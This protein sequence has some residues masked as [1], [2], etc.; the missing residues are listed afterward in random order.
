MA[1]NDP[2]RGPSVTET[3]LVRR[4]ALLAPSDAAAVPALVMTAGEQAGYRFLEFFAAHIRN[5]NTR[6]AYYRGTCDFFRFCEERGVR[7]LHEVRSHHVAA[8]VEALTKTCSAPTTKQRLAAVRMLF[9]WLIVGQ[10]VDRNPAQAVRG[11]RHVVET[12][13]TPVLEPDVARQL[14]DGIRTDTVVGLRDRA[15]IGLLVYSFARVSAAIAMNVRDYYPSGKK[16]WIRLLEKGGKHHEMPAHHELEEWLDLYLDVA[17]IR[18]DK[19]GPLFRTARGRTGEL[20]E[21]RMTRHDVRRMIRRRARD[22]GILTPIG[23][24]TWRATGITAYLTNGGELEKAQRMAAHSSPRTTK[25]YDR[26]ADRITLDEVERI[27]IR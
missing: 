22:A 3:E 19:K 26:R 10:V 2:N 23:C 24:H 25:L 9:D 8:Y 14:F 17:G 27:V 21:E 1:K 11:P 7:A 13:K 18:E 12:G 5:A 16:W 15:L 4:D 6:Q 20:T